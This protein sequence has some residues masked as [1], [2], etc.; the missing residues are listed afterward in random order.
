MLLAF[1]RRRACSLGIPVIHGSVVLCDR[2]GRTRV[3]VCGI[4]TP[5]NSTDFTSFFSMDMR[6]QSSHMLMLHLLAD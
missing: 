5:H 4:M 1:Q 2:F 3:L 6:Q